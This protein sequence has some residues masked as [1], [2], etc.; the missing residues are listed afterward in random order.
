MRAREGGLEY[1]VPC[2]SDEIHFCMAHHNNYNS[3]LYPNIKEH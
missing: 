1:Y 2:R 3:A